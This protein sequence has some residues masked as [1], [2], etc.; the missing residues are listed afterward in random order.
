MNQKLRVMSGMRTT[1]QLHVGNYFGALKNWIRLQEDHPCYFGAMNWHALTDG[2]KSPELFQKYVKDI[3]VTWLA[4]GIDPNKSVIFVQSQIPQ[5]LELNMIFTMLTPLPWLDRV[6][7]WKDAVEDMKV[8]DAYNLGRFS[9]PVLQTA[10]IA[11]FKGG[12]VPVGQDQLPHLELSREI[13]RRFNHLYG[14]KLPEP[15]SLLTETPAIP[16]LDGRKMSKSYGNVLP[17][18]DEP[19]Q[20]IKVVKGMVTDPARVKRTDPGNP[21]ICPVF[22]M[23]KLFSDKKTLDHVNVEC[24]RAG[25]GCMDCKMLLAGH[26]NKFVEAPLAKQKDLLNNPKG[27]DE[28]IG[29]GCQKA[30]GE[31]EKT[32]KEVK[33]VLGWQ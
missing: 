15:E 14:G 31:A 4:F 33:G 22:G 6:T 25:I 3:V 7:T 1:H 30:R 17:L 9:Y 28:I 10:D 21:D 11:I 23:H 19:E 27:L 8:K 16:G 18:L 20:I 26:I 24:R 12:K 13:I 2:Y 29:D 5:L 32:L